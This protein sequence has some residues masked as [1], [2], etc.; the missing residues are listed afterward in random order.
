MLPVAILA[1]GL[2]RRIRPLSEKTPKAL[3]EIEGR[4]FI[5]YQLELL[6]SQGI[7]KVVLCLG[8]LGE[9]IQEYLGNGERHG[10][11]VRCSF[12]GERPLGTGGAIKKALPLLGEHFFILYG[13]SYLPINYA[14]VE[15]A[16]RRSKKQGLMTVFRNEGRWD[17][18]N[19]VYVPCRAGD[20]PGDVVRYDKKTPSKEM[21]Y[22]DYGLSCCSAG[23][24]S[25][26]EGE[27]FD[28]ADVFARLSAEGQLAGFE[29][30]E[31]FYETGSFAGIDDFRRYINSSIRLTKNIQK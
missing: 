8:F 19:A 27:S 30:T 18:S 7:E 5:D 15:A 21:R 22:I 23:E 3:I 12:D 17:T 9:K 25:K 31:R 28:V 1:G 2:A 13:D 6:R 24:I 20:A 4:P 26:E 14:D 11:Q 10:L 29:T 16:Y